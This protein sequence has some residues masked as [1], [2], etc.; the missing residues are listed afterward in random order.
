MEGY[1][2]LA[3]VIIVGLLLLGLVLIPVFVATGT[4]H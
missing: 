3:A 2:A 1:D 4:V